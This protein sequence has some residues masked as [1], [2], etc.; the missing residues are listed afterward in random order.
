MSH[1][2]VVCKKYQER[3]ATTL[4]LGCGQKL[5]LLSELEQKPWKMFF[6]EYF[7]ENI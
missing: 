4:D 6:E 7:K 3:K 2:P 1:Y 5:G